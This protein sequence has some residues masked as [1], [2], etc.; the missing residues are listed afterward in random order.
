MHHQPN[1]IRRKGFTVIE[2]LVVVGIIAVL[3]GI[4]IVGIGKITAAQSRTQTRT[5]LASVHS[6]LGEFDRETSLKRQPPHMWSAANAM[7]LPT[8]AIVFDFWRDSDPNTPG[9]QGVDVTGLK[10]LGGDDAAARDDLPVV[11]NT[12]LAMYMFNQLGA[13]KKMLSAM[14]TESV[15]AIADAPPPAGYDE[16]AVG[17]PKDAWDNAIVLVPAS[18][19]RGVMLGD[20]IATRYA[21]TS[22]KTYKDGATAGPEILVNGDLAPNARPFF[23]SPGPDGRLETGD[24]NIYSFENQ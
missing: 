9:T 20:D 13:V 21:I 3:A 22:V 18:G 10:E 16:H 5:I 15:M 4:A 7:V 8:G 14:P 11:K 12:Q 1:F 17:I 6:M 2:L 24:D 23:A 19:L